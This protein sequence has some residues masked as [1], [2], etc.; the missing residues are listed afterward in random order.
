MLSLNQIFAN[1]IN[2]FR[3]NM[4]FEYRVNEISADVNAFEQFDSELTI[5]RKLTDLNERA[6]ELS[7]HWTA[8]K[9]DE[10]EAERSSYHAEMAKICQYKRL[11]IENLVHIINER[12]EFEETTDQMEVVSTVDAP[13][14]NEI[15]VPQLKMP[16]TT[17]H[18]AFEKF[19]AMRPIQMGDVNQIK[20]LGQMLVHF[21]KFMSDGDSMGFIPDAVLVSVVHSKLDITSRVSFSM[22]FRGNE[23]PRVSEV[24]SYFEFIVD[25]MEP[26]A[27]CVG[28]MVEDVRLKPSTS[29]EGAHAPKPVQ[30]VKKIMRLLCAHCNVRH[31]LHRCAQFKTATYSARSRTL[32]RYSLCFN[33]FSAG[34][35]AAE[36][37]DD[38]CDRCKTKHNSIMCRKHWD[39]EQ[40]K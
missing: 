32:N 7:A 8:L 30:Q 38:G 36:C 24:I 20:A 19:C 34:H 12:K 25:S 40:N 10:S 35:N 28:E 27:K 22:W 26:T 18:A 21:E 1:Q 13:K 23:N 31:P 37:P 4:A 15:V 29:S 39:A 14:E 5:A 2:V 9:P 16:Y 17:F 6:L 33:C 3:A 11:C